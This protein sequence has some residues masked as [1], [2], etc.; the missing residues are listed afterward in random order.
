[1]SEPEFP[2]GLQPTNQD[3]PV[4]LRRKLRTLW[5][6]AQTKALKAYGGVWRDAGAAQSVAQTTS[7]QILPGYTENRPSTSKRLTADYTTG[8]FTFEEPGYYV[9]TMSLT[10]DATSNNV[11]ADFGLR[12]DGVDPT[13]PTATVTFSNSSAVEVVSFSSFLTVTTVPVEVY[14]VTRGQS[15]FT[16]EFF[17]GGWYTRREDWLP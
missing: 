6:N 5:Q 14:L 11:T 10:L 7:W 16:M 13:F 17:V 4:P 9:A 8:L 1:M 3:L 12:V 2:F 15:S